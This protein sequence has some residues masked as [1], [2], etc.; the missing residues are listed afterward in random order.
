MIV[1]LATMLLSQTSP[2][3]PPWDRPVDRCTPSEWPVKG[4][5]TS[6]FGYRKLDCV[7]HEGID[8]R[9]KVGTK[10]RA[11]ADGQVMMAIDEADG[12]GTLLIIDHGHEST[13]YGHLSKILV[14]NGQNV[15]KGQVVALT[16]MTGNARGPHLHYEIHLGCCTHAATDPLIYL[17]E[18]P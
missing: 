3:P 15:K 14:K 5:V 17:K 11:P 6:G 8:I 16:G 2:C 1:L 7:V 10:V 9:A 13:Y 12:F 18:Q 4:K